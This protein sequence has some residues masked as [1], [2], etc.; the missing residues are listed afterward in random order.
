MT[1][2]ILIAVVAAAT[3]LLRVGGP[4]LLVH[5]GLPEAADR[6]LRYLAPAVLGGLVA[7]GM[8]SSGRS[9]VIDERVVGFA[10]AVG[11]AILRAPP[12]VVVATAA[13]ATSVARAF[14]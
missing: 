8:F 2:W 10:A 1:T 14:T 3:Y 12:L 5:L 11:T 9:L 13:A 7:V 4:L 6:V